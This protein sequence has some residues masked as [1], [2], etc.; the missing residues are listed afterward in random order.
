MVEEETVKSRLLSPKMS[1]ITFDSLMEI[2]MCN[3]PL[4]HFL[5]TSQRNP[6]PVV[7]ELFL[8]E[9]NNHQ[10]AWWAINGSP[11]CRKLLVDWAT[12]SR[13]NFSE[14]IADLN[15]VMD[16]LDK[17]GFCRHCDSSDLCSCNSGHCPSCD[18]TQCEEYA[19]KMGQPGARQKYLSTIRGQMI[20]D[21][22]FADGT[23][24]A[25]PETPETEEQPSF[26]D[27]ELEWDDF[28]SVQNHKATNDDAR[29]P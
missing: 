27:D 22:L 2:V 17:P 24:M 18:D 19:C 11:Y 1:A 28:L 13:H 8:E 23:P 16:E 7:M 6:Q 29:R 25:A 12:E 9:N 14:I 10:I 3:R 15:G 5:W 21:R 20:Y 26:S 4:R